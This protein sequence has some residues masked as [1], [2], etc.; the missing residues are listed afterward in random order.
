MIEEINK[1]V[2]D[3]NHLSNNKPSFSL[4]EKDIYQ[5]TNQNMASAIIGNHNNH[6]NQTNHT[7]HINI[8]NSNHNYN[9]N[10]KNGSYK[11]QNL[12]QFQFNGN[13]INSTDFHFYM[14]HYYDF[15]HLCH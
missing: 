11:N 2:K 6:I 9:F 5:K 10:L 12:S 3:K 4:K 14:L 8:A 7:N 13:G 15:F 1:N